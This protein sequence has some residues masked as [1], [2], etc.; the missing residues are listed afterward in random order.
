MRLEPIAPADLSA[1]Q[2]PLN[3]SMQA[4]V[5]KHLHGFIAKREDGALIGPFPAMLHF[6]QF[7][8]AAWS[9]FTALSQ[10]STLPKTAHEVAILV[11]GA[12]LNSRYELY[13]HERVA[14]L[15]GLSES[16]IA[17]ITA[18]QRPADLSAEEGI[19]YDVAACLSNGGQLHDTT[20]KAATDAFGKDGTAE[21][22]YLIG[23]YCMISVLLNAYDVPLPE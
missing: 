6:P 9:V 21:L 4:G 18:G 2:R 13:S 19:A 23:C 5:A 14:K 12:R 20:Y 22:F 11:T 7:G 16:K 10:N 15:A 17:T 3:D 8:T 1:E